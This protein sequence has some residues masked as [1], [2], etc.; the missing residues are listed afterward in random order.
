MP[1]RP[2]DE[3]QRASMRRKI[4][5]AARRLF[6]A[7]GVEALSMRNV[8]RD[9]DLSA[10][11]LYAYF[12]DKDQLMRAAMTDALERLVA[13]MEGNAKAQATP[14]AALAAMLKT[15]AHFAEREPEAFRVLFLGRDAASAGAA[16]TDTKGPYLLLRAAVAAAMPEGAARD[17]DLTAQAALAAVHGVVALKAALPDL[18]WTEPARLID[19]AVQ[20][21]LADLGKAPA[22]LAAPR[23][24]RGAEPR[25]I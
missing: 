16:A 9:L 25:L 19:R 17:A 10:G 20:Q 14:I 8:A 2:F 12:T 4:V 22:K 21:S 18:P 13:D 15:Y 23:A 24:K 6:A 5:A 3:L 11:A 1:R 7:G